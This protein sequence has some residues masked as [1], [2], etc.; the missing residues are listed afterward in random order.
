MSKINLKTLII[1][2]LILI[3]LNCVIGIFALYNAYLEG[4]PKQ[5]VKLTQQTFKK[6]RPTG[7]RLSFSIEN[8]NAD[9]NVAK[10]ENDE[11]ATKMLD[12]L[13]TK[14]GLP[15]EKITTSQQ[16]YQSRNDQNNNI[17]EQFITTNFFVDI[18]SVEV[19]S[20]IRN[21][22]VTQGVRNFNSGMYTLTKE[23]ITTICD[24]LEEENYKLIR[25]KV[26]QQLS[27]KF[28][29]WYSVKYN[30]FRE[31]CDVNKMYQYQ[32]G[33]GGGGGGNYSTG[34]I[35]YQIIG[36]AELELKS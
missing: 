17:T 26:Q 3:I 15:A 19:A 1:P 5:I 14:F 13:K 29:P 10:K 36:E 2:T 9:A 16:S 21:E 35:S 11:R 24:K 31:G 33:G 28:L 27:G 7:D 18:E 23:E 22:I 32:A 8:K 25:A 4:R 30:F 6:V 20:N 34:E 12:L